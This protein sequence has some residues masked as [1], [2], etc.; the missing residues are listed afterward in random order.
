MDIGGCVLGSDNSLLVKQVSCERFWLL[1]D[2]PTNKQILGDIEDLVQYYA[3][4]LRNHA[5][6][7]LG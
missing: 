2:F 1:F 3:I 4:L 5:H 6:K 7:L